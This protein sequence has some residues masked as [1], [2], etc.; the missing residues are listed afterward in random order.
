M[1]AA[2]VGSGRLSEL[3]QGYQYM[4]VSNSDNLGATLD[5]DIL[6]HF[7]ATESPFMLECCRRTEND[8]KGG[9]LAIRNSDQRLILR[10]SANCAG[11]DEDAFQDITRHRFFNTNNEKVDEFGGIIPLPI[12]KNS[13]TVDPKDGSSEGCS[14]RDCHGVSC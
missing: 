2:L 14:A 1:Y 13:K 12:I 8:K 3:L 4:F 9:H 10:E 11:D 7:A 6:T 5:Q